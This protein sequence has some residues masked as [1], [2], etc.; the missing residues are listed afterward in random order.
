MA[1]VLTPEQRKRNM[2][3]IKGKDTKI[4]CILRKALWDKG[5]RY[6]K[7]YKELPGTP[8]I[9]LCKY[10]IVIF[11]DGEFFHGKNWDELKIK[12]NESKNSAFWID[13]ISR[14]IEHDKEINAQLKGLGWT[15]L[16][17]WGRDIRHNTLQCIK[18]IEESVFEFKLKSL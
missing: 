16:R 2:R 5:Y 6:R 11:C 12:L 3:S 9:V 7:N 14:N 18:A 15:V 13:K 8:D 1:D 17:F 10:R 4:E